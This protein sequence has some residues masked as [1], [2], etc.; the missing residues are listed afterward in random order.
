MMM[1][2]L[3]DNPVSSDRNFTDDEIYDEMYDEIYEI[4]DEKV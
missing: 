3:S 4:Y 1:A 2:S